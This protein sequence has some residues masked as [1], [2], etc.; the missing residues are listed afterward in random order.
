MFRQD[1]RQQPL[2]LQVFRFLCMPSVLL[3]HPEIPERRLQRAAE[4]ARHAERM[5]QAIRGGRTDHAAGRT[6][7]I[8][9][10]FAL[11]G[12]R[13]HKARKRQPNQTGS[14]TTR[15]RSA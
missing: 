7:P 15:R 2:L 12:A 8:D 13:K 1:N 14:W 5:A 4:E 11:I 10:A 6:H 9:E 3:E